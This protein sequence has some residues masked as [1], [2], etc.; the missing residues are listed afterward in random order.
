MPSPS[1]SLARIALSFTLMASGVSFL[2][3]APVD[4]GREILP[5]L[6]ENCFHCHGPDSKGRKADLRLDTRE[7]ALLKNAE[8]SAAVVP[9]KPEASS[10]VERIFSHDRDEVMPPPKS[11]RKLSAK[12]RDLL[13]R[14]VQEG[15]PWGSH[16]AFAPLEKPLLPQNG[17][18]H[19]IDALVR[20]RLRSEG[21]ELQP[22]AP[23]RT[24]LRRLSLDLTGLPPSAEQIAAFD[25]LSAPDALERTVD[26]LLSSPHFGERMAWDWLD[27]ARYA[28]S[29]GYQGDLERT[30]WPWRDWVVSA[31]NRNLPYD[32]FTLWQLAG[33]LLPGATHEQTLAT[34]FLRNHPING[35][36]GRIAEENRVDYVMDMAETTGTVWLGLTLNC[37]RCHDHKYDP[38]LQTD[39]YRFFAFF[40]QTPVNGGGGDP[41]TAPK[42]DV[43]SDKEVE[44][45]AA[46]K[47][48]LAD[49]QKALTAQWQAELDARTA[50]ASKIL[51]QATPSPEDARANKSNGLSG[52]LRLPE[53]KWTADQRKTV[54]EAWA[55]KDAPFRALL[56]DRNAKKQAFEKMDKAIPRVMVMADMPKPRQTFLLD[57]GLYNQ[58]KQAVTAGV[59]LSLP[60]LPQE[61]PANRLGLAHWLVSAPNPLMARVTVNR[62]WQQLF[63]IGLVKTAE[64]FGV[65]AE[66]P[67]HRNLLDWLAAEFRDSG[68]DLKA[69]IRLI[70]T[71]ET[72]LQSSE[73]PEGLA[74]RDPQNRLLARGARF[75]MPSWMIRD[76]ALAA[77]GLLVRK[78]GG[79]PVRPY[80]PAGVWEEATFGNKK[81]VPDRG[82]SLYRRSL[83]T[84]WRRIIAPTMFFDTPNRT[85]CNVKPLRTNTPLHA[86]NT[87]N[88]PAYV[89]AARVLAQRLLHNSG[90]HPETVIRGAYQAVLIREP[91]REEMDLW[92]QA[93]HQRIAQFQ[94]QQENA[95]RLLSV[96]DSPRDATLPAAEHAAYTT[97]CLSLLNLDEALT[98]E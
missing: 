27:A 53:A 43:A 93:I 25:S 86:L 14:W 94:G 71:S 84:F 96:G 68:W 59:P 2:H 38:L 13:Q 78:I 32:Q 49:A 10:L 42:L 30:M 83:Y 36:G 12:E 55:K 70:V 26:Q 40:N 73:L 18:P 76:Q 51:E 54:E 89:E 97:L 74:E 46:A 48:A 19:P 22:R 3:A 50:W 66:T 77:S 4:F 8:G 5:I 45:L 37:C 28:D 35:E 24:L 29:N 80:Q 64:D 56:T 61:Q 79:E 33:D 31:F 21:L 88:D 81:Y 52:I 1:A 65:Q 63:G 41:Q 20:E 6:S 44:T 69:L 57:R 95:N 16:W 67:M 60:P 92:T 9:G 34:G 75:R 82:E 11:N 15:A 17:S 72:Y 39:Y 85:N 7:G 47:T 98:K 87:L 62:L 91:S 58:P 90:N 23:K